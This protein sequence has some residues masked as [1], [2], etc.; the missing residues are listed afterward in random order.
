[1]QRVKYRVSPALILVLILLTSAATAQITSATLSGFLRDASG[2][3]VTDVTLTARSIETNL[4][5]TVLS[6]HAGQYSF[7]ALPPGRYTLTASKPGFARL[8]ENGVKLTVGQSAV[9]NLH[10]QPGGEHDTV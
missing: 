1:M 6:G 7:N 4:T 10:L 9:V 3:G 5:T 2:A 8:I